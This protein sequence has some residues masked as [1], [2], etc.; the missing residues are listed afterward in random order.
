MKTIAARSSTSLDE[1]L[2]QIE[3]EDIFVMRDGRFVQVGSPETVVAEPV[4]DYVRDGA[5]CPILYPLG[6]VQATIDA[7]A[8]R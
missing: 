2:P 6:D 8:R 7:F 1:L 4:D 3:K 5:T